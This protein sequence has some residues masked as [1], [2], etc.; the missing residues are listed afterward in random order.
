MQEREQEKFMVANQGTVGQT[1]PLYWKKPLHPRTSGTQYA[2][3]LL[4]YE[5]PT[6]GQNL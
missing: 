4:P 5:G 1:E 6:Y 2:A 3:Y